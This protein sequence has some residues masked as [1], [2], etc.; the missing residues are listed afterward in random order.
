MYNLLLSLVDKTAA[1]VAAS[2]NLARVD[3]AR[4][5]G[6]KIK[7]FKAER[8]MSLRRPAAPFT[9]QLSAGAQ[10]AAT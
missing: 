1:I 6:V 3:L 2:D 9:G 5:S 10:D 7:I 8:E 4:F